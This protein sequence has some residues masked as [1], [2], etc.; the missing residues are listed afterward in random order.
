MKFDLKRIGN[1]WA[2]LIPMDERA[3]EKLQKDLDVEYCKSYLTTYGK[4]LD[5]IQ[6]GFFN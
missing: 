1:C 3:R 6:L 5:Y 2:E 4:A